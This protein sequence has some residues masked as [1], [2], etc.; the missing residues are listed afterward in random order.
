MPIASAMRKDWKKTYA[1]LKKDIIYKMHF[2]KI[3]NMVI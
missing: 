3:N 2:I 1:K